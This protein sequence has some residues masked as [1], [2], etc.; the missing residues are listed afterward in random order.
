MNLPAP[1]KSGGIPL[2]QALNQ[3]RTNREFN[4]KP[5]D[6]QTISDLLWA[7]CGVNRPEEGKRT[8]PTARNWQEIDVYVTLESGL[9]LYDAKS[10]TLVV[11][12]DT[13]LRDLAGI[14]DFTNTAPI[15]LTYVVDYERME[16][17]DDEAKAFYSAVD[18]GFISQNVYLF[19]ASR[20][21]NT[22]V[23]GMVDKVAL[24]KALCLKP[25]QKV[26]LSQTVGYPAK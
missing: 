23:M 1:D 13:D 6:V 11:K 14:Q 8:A 15:N 17:A 16:N 19:C 3:R 9:Y 7:A 18:T 4:S 10:H 12:N 26:I 21:L 5:L 2:M 20:G 22:V 24:G 25:S